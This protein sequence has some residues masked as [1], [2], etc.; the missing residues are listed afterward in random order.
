MRTD[1]NLDAV[2]EALQKHCGDMF[3]AAQAAGISPLRLDQWLRDDEEARARVEEAQRVGWMGLESEARRRAVEG[4]SEPVFYKGDVVGYKQQYSDG[5]LGKLLE[6]RVP[7]YKKGDD[8]ARMNF[9]GNTQINI[10]PRANNFD[11]WLAMRDRTLEDREQAALPEPAQ[12]EEVLED[13][14]LAH[15]KDIL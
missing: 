3:K 6:A 9:L 1:D 14:P 7:A 4:V 10:M 15:L 8:A 5:L 13:K 2:C 12:F 11:E